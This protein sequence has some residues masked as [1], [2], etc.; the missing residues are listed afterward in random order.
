[1][2]GT[3]N[4]LFLFRAVTGLVAKSAP[5]RVLGRCSKRHE[6]G[7]PAHRSASDST[8]CRALECV[9]CPF[10]SPNLLGLRRPFFY[11]R[12][13][14]D[15]RELT[16]GVSSL[17]CW[18]HLQTWENWVSLDTTTRSSVR[19]VVPQTFM[20]RPVQSDTRLHGTVQARGDVLHETCHCGPEASMSDEEDG[21]GFLLW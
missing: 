14:M 6:H 16:E 13:H 19:H 7:C 4:K 20:A 12:S 2:Q 21:C 1:M 17:W 11:A 8:L 18:S 9:W 10:D 15:N 3:C 5:P